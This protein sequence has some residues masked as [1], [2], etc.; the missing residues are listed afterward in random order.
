MTIAIDKVVLDLISLFLTSAGVFSVLTKF[1]VPQLNLMYMGHNPHAI[2]RDAIDSVSTWIFL[3]LGFG[4]ILIQGYSI[5]NDGSLKRS[6]TRDWYF[7]AFFVGL[8]S[9]LLLTYLLGK[10]G[11]FFA[12][13]KWLPELGRRYAKNL[14]FL[15]FMIGHESEWSQRYKDRK[16]IKDIKT[17][18]SFRITNIE[19]AQ[20]MIADLE[21]L[22]EIDKKDSG[23]VNRLL[24]VHKLIL[25]Y[26]VTEDV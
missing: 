25:P 11:K 20:E 2:K 24:R 19:S 7:V 26:Y 14:E 6:Q 10:V 8:V 22:F 16:R 1:Y 18:E 3:I 9:T 23:W 21:T 17:E 15:H 12:K 13:R 5:I 4:G